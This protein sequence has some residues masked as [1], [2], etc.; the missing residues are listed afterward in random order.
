M[1]GHEYVLRAACSTDVSSA[2]TMPAPPMANL[3]RCTRCQSVG[4]P[5]LARY[6]DMGDTTTRF[7]ATSPRSRIGVKRSGAGIMES[8]IGCASSKYPRW[9]AQEHGSKLHFVDPHFIAVAEVDVFDPPPWRGAEW[10]KPLRRKQACA[11]CHLPRSWSP[12]LRGLARAMAR[13]PRIRRPTR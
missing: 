4:A 5:S 12:S 1:P 10:A 7:R 2:N 3:P 11:D 13:L 6:C 8:L 9:R